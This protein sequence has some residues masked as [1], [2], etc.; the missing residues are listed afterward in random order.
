MEGFV[1]FMNEQNTKNTNYE[2]EQ[3]FL[4]EKSGTIQLREK[5]K[6]GQPKFRLVFT[7]LAT[8]VTEEY[9]YKNYQKIHNFFRNLAN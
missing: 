2:I 4:E 3:F 7:N 8:E 5:K 6:V 9:D 1:Q